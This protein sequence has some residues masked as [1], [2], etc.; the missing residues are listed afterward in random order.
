MQA[1]VRRGHGVCALIFAPLVR[2]TLPNDLAGT[3]KGATERRPLFL[4]PSESL[5]VGIECGGHARALT[6]GELEHTG[7]IRIVHEV[8]DRIRSG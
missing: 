6:T 2:I 5:A 1:Q 3:K 8:G 7:V 4:P